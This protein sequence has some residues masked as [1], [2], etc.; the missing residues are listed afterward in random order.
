MARWKGIQN[1]EGEKRGKWSNI[2]EVSPSKEVFNKMS[3]FKAEQ[4][5][6]GPNDILHF[7]F[8]PSETLFWIVE[9]IKREMLPS[10]PKWNETKFI[11]TA[12]LK[13]KYKQADIVSH[14]IV[15]DGESEEWRW[16]GWV[17]SAVWV[18]NWQMHFWKWI[19][20]H[21]M[22]RFCQS[23]A[24]KLH[25]CLSSKRCWTTKLLF[26]NTAPCA[27]VLNRFIY[28]TQTWLESVRRKVPASCSIPAEE[29]G[30]RQGWWR[31][32]WKQ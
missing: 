21:K 8:F 10:A 1:W 2:L 17:K 22:Q 6:K 5:D 13:K 20:K 15:T 28:L 3:V 4:L 29:T 7:F 19:G 32:G 26:L 23:A 11:F 27:E 24:R 16:S 31:E 12:S 14:L 18:H 30:S 9:D 25:S